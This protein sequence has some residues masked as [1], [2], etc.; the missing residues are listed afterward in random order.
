MDIIARGRR[1]LFGE[2]ITLPLSEDMLGDIDASLDRGEARLSFVR[3][4]IRRELSRRSSVKEGYFV[5]ATVS[6]AI[7]GKV[8]FR[9]ELRGRDVVIFESNDYRASGDEA[10]AAILDR[11]AEFGVDAVVVIGTLPGAVNPRD[12]EEALPYDAGRTYARRGEVFEPFNEFP[13]HME[14]FSAVLEVIEQVA[15]RR[16]VEPKTP[17]A[18]TRAAIEEARAIRAAKEPV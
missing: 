18:E 15:R 7:N 10:L 14:S 6:E 13:I 8:F 12:A 17:N 11:G 5:R 9:T 2:R 4:A 16:K 1:K 3:E